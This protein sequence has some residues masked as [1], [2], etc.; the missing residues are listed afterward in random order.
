MRVAVTGATGLIGSALVRELQARGDQVTVLTRDEV[1]RAQLARGSD[2]ALGV[3]RPTLG[4][5]LARQ[6]HDGVATGE[7]LGG[8][9]LISGI[10]PL[11]RHDPRERLP[12]ALGIPR[13]D[14]HLV[15]ASLQLAHDG[16][17]DQP[18]GAGDRYAHG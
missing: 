10:P 1:P 11:A 5:R 9:R 14:G 6:V 7:R 2:A 16:A 17:T 4:D 8:R 13:Q 15:S 3:V 18:R 12:G